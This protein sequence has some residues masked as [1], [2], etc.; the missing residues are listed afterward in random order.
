MVEVVKEVKNEEIDVTVESQE[1]SKETMT[2]T[3]AVELR[4]KIIESLS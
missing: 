2:Y 1:K 4:G 3:S